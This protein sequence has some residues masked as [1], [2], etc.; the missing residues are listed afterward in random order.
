MIRVVALYGISSLLL[1]HASVNQ[2]TNKNL[3]FTR[4][5]NLDK[6]FHFQF[7]MCITAKNILIIVWVIEGL[8]DKR[9]KVSYKAITLNTSRYLLC[10]QLIIN[11]TKK[12]YNNNDHCAVLLL[13]SLYIQLLN[14]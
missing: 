13:N 1:S 14:Y 4:Q 3:V 11:Y 6:K 2:Q 8:G 9:E 10:E 7:L 12:G 5:S